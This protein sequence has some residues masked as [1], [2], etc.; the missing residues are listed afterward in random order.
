MSLSARQPWHVAQV[1]DDSG[2]NS[3]T[4]Q[5]K[6]NVTTCS[7]RCFAT[8]LWACKDPKTICMS[9]EKDGECGHFSHSGGPELTGR[10]EERS[11]GTSTK[12]QVITLHID[13][14]Y[15]RNRQFCMGQSA[16]NSTS[17]KRYA[18]NE[19]TSDVASPCSVILIW[20]SFL[21]QRAKRGDDREHVDM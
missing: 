10:R 2:M 9:L 4:E 12:A 7:S 13:Q 17:N 19:L 21:E 18:C 14:R 15:R 3:T 11:L 1:R 8:F 5:E 20:R 6:C 16:E